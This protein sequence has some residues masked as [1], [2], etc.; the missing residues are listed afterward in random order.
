MAAITKLA[1]KKNEAEHPKSDMKPTSIAYAF[2]LNPDCSG[3]F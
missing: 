3:P 2:W 1:N